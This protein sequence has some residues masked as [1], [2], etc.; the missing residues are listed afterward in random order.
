MTSDPVFYR[1][2]AAAEH[3]AAEAAT[4][5]NVRDRAQRAEAA[6]TRMAERAEHT[7]SQRETREAA[8]AAARLAAS[9]ELA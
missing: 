9:D 7:L 3:A 1:A 6:W 5:D 2:R 8:A 4:L